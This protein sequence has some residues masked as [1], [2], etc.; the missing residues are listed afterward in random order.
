MKTAA[1]RTKPAAEKRGERFE[2]V[3]ETVIDHT[4]GLTWS[5]ANVPGG[6]MKWKDAQEAC[7]AVELADLKWRAPTRIELLT[8]VDDTRYDQAIAPVFKCESAGYWTSTP[9]AGSP[10]VYAWYVDFYDGYS[11]CHDQHHEFF[12]RAVCASQ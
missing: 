7:G 10:G 4:T 11:D 9:A 3:G 2:V 8:I 6:R 1:K 5:R 12:V